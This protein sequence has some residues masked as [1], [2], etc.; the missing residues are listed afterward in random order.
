VHPR[1]P[2][3]V[4]SLDFSQL[5]KGPL[6]LSLCG[7]FKDTGTGLVEWLRVSSKCETLSSNPSAAKKKKKDVEVVGTL[8]YLVFSKTTVF[9]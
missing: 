5:D 3:C 9:R 6:F 4:S 2:V 1:L 8:E 7:S